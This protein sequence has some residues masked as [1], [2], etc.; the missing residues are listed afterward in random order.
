MEG[1]GGCLWLGVIPGHKAKGMKAFY[2]GW[3]VGGGQNLSKILLQNLKK[4]LTQKFRF[5][6]AYFTISWLH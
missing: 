6:L 1:G 3:G 2:K 5:R 4:F